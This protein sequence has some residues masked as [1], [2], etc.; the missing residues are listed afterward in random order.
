MDLYDTD[1]LICF[2]SNRIENA[3][4]CSFPKRRHVKFRHWGITERKNT[5]FTKWKNF[6]MKYRNSFI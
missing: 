1:M 6:E 2:L 3:V 4:L 5:T